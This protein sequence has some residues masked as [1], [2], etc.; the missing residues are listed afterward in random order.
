MEQ[1]VSGYVRPPNVASFAK[2]RSMNRQVSGY[3]RPPTAVRTVSDV[4]T[5]FN[6]VPLSVYA[7]VKQSPSTTRVIQGKR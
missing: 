2:D 5:D 6:G 3:V 7:D 4:K 1:Q